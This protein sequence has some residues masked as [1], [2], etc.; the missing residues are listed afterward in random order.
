MRS[1]NRV[2][3]IVC[4]SSEEEN[5]FKR[6]GKVIQESEKKDIVLKIFAM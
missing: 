2:A 1:V 5:V 6:L 3:K 4:T